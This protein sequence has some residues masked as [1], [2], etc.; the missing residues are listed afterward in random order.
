[1]IANNKMNGS[2]K[3]MIVDDHPAVIEGLS[4]WISRQADMEFCCSAMDAINALA[5]IRSNRPDVVVL[6]L[7]LKESDGIDLLKQIVA[8]DDRIQVLVCSMHPEIPFAER[9]LNNGA[10]GFISKQSESSQIIEAIRTVAQGEFY[11]SKLVSDRLMSKVFGKSKPPKSVIS[12]ENLSDRE[13]QVFQHLGE[14]MTTAEIS[15]RMHL[16]SH[17]IETYRQRMKAKMGIKS[18][19]ELACKATK[20][21]LEMQR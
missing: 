6:D 1:M 15:V 4:M 20:W 19:S 13:L 16:S 10:R 17:T 21:L 3:V 2:I 11:T 9:T 18:N 12:L 8:K 5:K 7:S 14:G